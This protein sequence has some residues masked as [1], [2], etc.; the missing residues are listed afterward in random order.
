MIMSILPL[1]VA[2]QA[3]A[4]FTSPVHQAPVA[5][6]HVAARVRDAGITGEALRAIKPGMSYQ[7][8]VAIIGS[9]GTR[10]T[11]MNMGG[12]VSE[13]FQ[14]KAGPLKWIQ[15]MFTDGHAAMSSQVGLY[16]RTADRT[17]TAAQW[18]KLTE[19]MSVDEAMQAIGTPGAFT[20]FTKIMD[21]VS[22]GYLWY[23]RGMASVATASFT[24]GHL[25][26]MMQVG[27]N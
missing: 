5:K 19:G 23:G 22:E 8:V 7:E 4:P 24:N 11:S 27:L 21:S 18:G 3:A 10:S 15:V 12:T 2:L 6:T 13:S 16:P 20:G 25:S 9:E 26:T 1:L 17:I 14:W